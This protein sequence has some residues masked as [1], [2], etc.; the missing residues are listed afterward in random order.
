LRQAYPMVHIVA[1][2]RDLADLVR[3]AKAGASAVV[4]E[5]LEASLQL[6][7]TVLRL[8]GTPGDEIDRTLADFRRQDYA[9]LDERQSASEDDENSA[10][11]GA[12]D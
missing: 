5:A 2:G 12:G 9:A 6:G 3:L 7:A 8:T 1:R 10:K 4:P 11:R